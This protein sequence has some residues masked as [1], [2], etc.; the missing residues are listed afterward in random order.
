[1]NKQF[2]LNKVTLKHA[3]WAIIRKKRSRENKTFA[4]YHLVFIQISN[5]PIGEGVGG[6]NAPNILKIA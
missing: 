6:R 3:N 4:I 5:V 2:T 1:M